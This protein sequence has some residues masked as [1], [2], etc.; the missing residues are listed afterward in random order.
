MWAFNKQLL[1]WMKGI[2]DFVA[3]KTDNAPFYRY[4]LQRRESKNWKEMMWKGDFAIANPS[5]EVHILSCPAVDCVC[6]MSC[7]RI[8]V[9]SAMFIV[10]PKVLSC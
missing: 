9:D 3:T 5:I 2:I 8:C 6:P 4:L 10:S 1:P 7:S